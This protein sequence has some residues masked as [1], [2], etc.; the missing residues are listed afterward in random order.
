MISNLSILMHHNITPDRA[1]TDFVEELNI[2]ID[3]MS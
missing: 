3:I 2:L 1:I